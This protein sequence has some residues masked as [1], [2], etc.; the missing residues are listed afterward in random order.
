[1]NTRELHAYRAP[2]ISPRSPAR[3]RQR[4]NQCSPRSGEHT[5]VFAGPL[6]S[7]LL[8]ALAERA[9]AQGERFMRSKKLGFL[10][11]CKY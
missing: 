8:Q 1:M 9:E 6:P 5:A 2:A 4:Y 7:P 11:S 3:Q 10:S